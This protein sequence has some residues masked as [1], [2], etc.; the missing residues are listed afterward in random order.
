MGVAAFAAFDLAYDRF[1]RRW[2][3]G[4]CHSDLRG[5]DGDSNGDQYPVRPV[6]ADLAIREHSGPCRIALAVLVGSALAAATVFVLSRWGSVRG[7]SD[8]PVSFWFSESLLTLIVLAAS[9]LSVRA[10]S[11]WSIH[12]SP[13]M[14]SAGGRRSSTAPAASESWLR[15][16]LDET[17]LPESFPSGSWTTILRSRTTSSTACSFS[18]PSTCFEPRSPAPAHGRC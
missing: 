10:A 17:L 3:R 12:G 6:F 13:E 9:R 5:P 2:R 1:L 18:E 15:G 16:R 4:S 11:D 7:G 14:R 8:L